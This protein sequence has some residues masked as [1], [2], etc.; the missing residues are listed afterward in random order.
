MDSMRASRSRWW[1]R[2]RQALR[3]RSRRVLTIVQEAELVL[4]EDYMVRVMP[5][6]MKGD[7]ERREGSKQAALEAFRAAHGDAGSRT[8][9]N[10]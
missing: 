9:R 1:R 8:E 3:P 4:L 6:L 2:L 7:P 5:S 10:L